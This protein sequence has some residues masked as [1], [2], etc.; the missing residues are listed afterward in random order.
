MTNQ[1]YAVWSAY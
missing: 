1:P